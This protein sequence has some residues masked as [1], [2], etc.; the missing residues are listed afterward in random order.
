MI[1]WIKAFRFPISFMGAGLV[2]LGFRITKLP[3]PWLVPLTSLIILSATML[4]NDWRDRFHDIK[5]GKTLAFKHPQG[6][7]IL[8][9]II[10][11]IAILLTITLWLSDYRLGIIPTIAITIGLVYSE[12]RLIPLM[13]TMLVAIGTAI[14]PLFPILFEQKSVVIISISTFFIIFAREVIKDIQDIE[15]DSNY[16]WTL[17]KKLGPEKSYGMISILLF[18]GLC[19]IP[20]SSSWRINT[21]IIILLITPFFIILAKEKFKLAKCFLDIELSGIILWLILGLSFN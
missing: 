3:I 14:L 7:L 19:F 12:T 16:K 8:T 20:Y 11:I 15:I 21:L 5:K 17:P 4:H 10:W 9:L 1:A 2:I 13:P 6:F 18:T